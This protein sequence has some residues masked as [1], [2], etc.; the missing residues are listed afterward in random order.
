MGNPYR[1]EVSL[2][3]DGRRLALRLTLGAL[4]ELETAFGAEG[5][6]ALG[7]RLGEGRLAARDLLRLLGP[8]ARGGG[9][10]ESDAELAAHLGAQDLPAVV[11]AIADCFAA[12]MPREASPHPRVPQAKP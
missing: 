2:D 4:A 11:G 3:L 10:H 7:H 6:A 8:L 9:A 1:G 12:A 5:L